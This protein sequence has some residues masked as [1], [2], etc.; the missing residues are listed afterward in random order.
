MNTYYDFLD[1]PVGKLLVVTTPRGI[2]H[3]L[4]DDGREPL[5]I[6]PAWHRDRAALSDVRDQFDQYFEGS[7]T[8]FEIPL[9]P[10]GTPFQQAVWRELRT[11]EFGQ[12]VSYGEIARRVADD[13]GASRAV[14]AANGQNPI[15]IIVPCHRV[16]GANGKL[17]GYGGGLPRK[18]FL[19]EHEQR[20]RPFALA[21]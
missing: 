3:V 17:T 10:N 13:V 4:F 11:I 8:A 9:A 5:R 19:L 6:D 1:S 7:R 12:T 16:I 20:H 2:S 18:K 15:A 21:P 14:G